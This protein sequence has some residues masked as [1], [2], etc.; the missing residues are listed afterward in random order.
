MS[1]ICYI[2]I[3]IFTGFVAGKIMKDGGFGL[4]VNLIP[5]YYW[6]RAG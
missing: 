6:P 2:L 5:W 3:G 1:F 4:L